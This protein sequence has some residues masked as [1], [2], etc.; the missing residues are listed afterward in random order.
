M[1]TPAMI[2]TEATATFFIP[3]FSISPS[4]SSST[5]FKNIFTWSTNYPG[6][7]LGIY[8]DNSADQ[9]VFPETLLTTKEA[10][11]NV[12]A[13][14]SLRP[15]STDS[16]LLGMEVLF[17]QRASSA[18]VHMCQFLAWVETPDFIFKYRLQ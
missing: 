11:T 15:W 8:V 9:K 4:S 12:G 10:S 16:W 18:L 14:G 2:E 7:G 17:S 13:G 3:L 1:V 6:G 5:A